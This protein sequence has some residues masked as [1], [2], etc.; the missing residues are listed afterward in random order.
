MISR[1]LFG[2]GKTSFPYA[3]AT[4]NGPYNPYRYKPHIVPNNY[5]TTEEI[6]HI[7]S[8]FYTDAPTP[9]RNVRHINPV[10]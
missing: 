9:V 8:R 10:R 2:L 7:A 5:P 4:R 3:F 1:K 6:K